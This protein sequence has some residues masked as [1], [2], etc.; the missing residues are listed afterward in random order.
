MVI[1]WAALFCM[2]RN[3]ARELHAMTAN[4]LLLA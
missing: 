4:G 1:D 2:Q 3:I